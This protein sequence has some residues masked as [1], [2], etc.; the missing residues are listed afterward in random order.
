MKLGRY[1][2]IP[3]RPADVECLW[4][5]AEPLDHSHLPDWL[6]A[7][8]AAAYRY[9]GSTSSAD[10]PAD[11]RPGYI[12]DLEQLEL[13]GLVV[14]HDGLNPSGYRIYVPEPAAQDLWSIG[15]YYGTSPFSL[16]PHPGRSNPVLTLNDVSDVPATLVA[17]PF[18]LRVHDTWHM[19]F[20]VFNW[21]S[22][23]GEI[24]LA[25][26]RD[27]LSW[28][29]QQIVLTEPFHLSY[30]YVFEWMGDYYMIPE[31]YQ[32][33]SIRLYRAVDFPLRWTHVGNLLEGSYFVDPSIFR[34]KEQWWL[35]TETNPEMKHDTLRLY[36]AAHLMGPWRE[37]S[38]SP[39]VSGDPEAARPGGRVLVI[40]GRV[41]RFS[42]N[43]VPSYGTSVR[44][45][46]FTKLTAADYAESEVGRRPIIGPGADD[47]NISGMHHV[48]AHQLDDGTWI[49]S[50][51]GWRSAEHQLLACHTA[52]ELS[53]RGFS[54]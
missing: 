39:I 16:A 46:E 5:N 42:Q 1:F 27:G 10:L 41:F 44:A 29:Y 14:D 40:N 36:S 18:M 34:Y 6:T 33:G 21:R 17:D 47:W 32:S 13:S 50:V 54:R 43:C 52:S 22:N 37:H 25:T 31:S 24:G 35:L 26:S 19:F 23:K 48:D 4:T 2:R 8:D 3:E 49:A 45:F 30:P 28:T 38:R 20:E 51:D 12:E 11:E 15:I 9:V 53:R 7:E